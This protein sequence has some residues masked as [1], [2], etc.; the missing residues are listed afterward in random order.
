MRETLPRI[1]AKKWGKWNVKWWN[2]KTVRRS[3]LANICPIWPWILIQDRVKR[4]IF[5]ETFF[6][7]PFQDRV[8]GCT[9]YVE[10]GG[11]NTPDGGGALPF[12]NHAKRCHV[13]CRNPLPK[14]GL[15]R[16]YL[17]LWIFFT[18]ERCNKLRKLLKDI[19]ISKLKC[20][21]DKKIPENDCRKLVQPRT[22][23]SRCTRTWQTQKQN[24]S[25][26]FCFLRK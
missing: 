6:R 16:N 22:F 7:K 17:K 12:E 5:V 23:C 14:D 1:F 18:S 10:G 20:V 19:E 25:W 2:A 21:A 26:I 8:G 11:G 13:S 9:R 15:V 3:W 4:K 24:Q